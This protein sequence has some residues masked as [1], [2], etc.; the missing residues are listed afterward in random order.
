MSESSNKNWRELCAAVASESDP[1]KL[2]L[3]VEE[4]IRV[5]DERR[6]QLHVATHQPTHTNRLSAIK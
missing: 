6:S 4:L 5:L 1:K 3:L 2:G